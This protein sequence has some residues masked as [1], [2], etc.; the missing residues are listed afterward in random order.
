MAMADYLTPDRRRLLINLLSLFAGAFLVVAG[1]FGCTAPILGGGFVYFI[2]ALYAIVFGLMVL[3]VEIKVSTRV[4]K[5]ALA[6]AWIDKYL[7]FLT[8][9]RGKGLFYIGVGILVFFIAP[10]TSGSM[11]G[12]W[13]VNNV[14]ALVLTIVGVLH[15]FYV[16]RDD[17]AGSAG[18]AAAIELQTGDGL[19]F[20]QPVPKGSST[21]TKQQWKK[22][23]EDGEL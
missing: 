19:D 18:S 21:T 14:A 2:G 16:V 11:F 12:R 7:K 5:V 9:Q 13:G 1:I 22:M 3:V 4:P 8:L 6:Y 10:N 17:S 23:V 15:A 20:S